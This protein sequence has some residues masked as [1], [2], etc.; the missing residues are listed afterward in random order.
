MNASP[1]FV[2]RRLGLV[3]SCPLMF[4]LCGGALADCLDRRVMLIRRQLVSVVVTLSL[5]VAFQPE[6]SLFVV[7]VFAVTRGVPLSSDRPARHALMPCLAP[8]PLLMNAVALQSAANNMSP[9]NPFPLV[10]L[11]AVCIVIILIVAA[12]VPALRAIGMESNRQF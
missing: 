8:R 6:P 7:F 3:A 1:G 5:A 2:Y 4:G 9:D 11:A 10:V 12:Q